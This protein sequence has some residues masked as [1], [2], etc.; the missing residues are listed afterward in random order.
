[1]LKRLFDFIASLLGLLILFPFFLAVGLIIKIDSNGPVFYKQSRIG[2]FGREF[3]I[4][5]FR[6]MYL[7]S[8]KKG[9]LS[10]GNQD[11]R[12]TKIGYYLRKYK[13]DELA[14][15]INVVFGEMSL[16]GPR[17]EVNKYVEMYSKE[18][19]SILSVKPGITDYAS[20]YFR[21]ETELLKNAANP[22]KFYVE[23][24]L[25]KKLTLNKKYL[26]EKSFF[27]DLKIIFKT[28]L[29]IIK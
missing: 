24:I 3:K 11:N 26:A 19:R 1:M 29:V 20:I 16:V 18:D 17:P 22:E 28:L 12:I 5:K 14:Q 4:Y 6:T 8:D 13:V 25:P 9:M 2:V 15:L 7:G 27:V 10:I 21:D 23:K